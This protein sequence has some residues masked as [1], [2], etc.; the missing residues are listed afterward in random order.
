MNCSQN[1]P[2]SY[3]VEDFYEHVEDHNFHSGTFVEIQLGLKSI[4]SIPSFSLLT[5][6]FGVERCQRHFIVTT[7]L[8][9]VVCSIVDF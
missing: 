7:S 3:S 4:T 5:F 6:T 2:W 8:L 1:N 9:Y